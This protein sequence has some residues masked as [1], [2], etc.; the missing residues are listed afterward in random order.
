MPL[1]ETDTKDGNYVD[2]IFTADNRGIV[3][4][5][6]NSGNFKFNMMGRYEFTNLA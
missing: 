5:L 1:I 6:K 4:L 2:E 3:G